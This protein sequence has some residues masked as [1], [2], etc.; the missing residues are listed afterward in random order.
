MSY[1]LFVTG[2]SL[3][4]PRLH[5]EHST[6]T[7]KLS[8]LAENLAFQSLHIQLAI[9]EL[10]GVG[11]LRLISQYWNS[12][13]STKSRAIDSEQPQAYLL[14]Q[15]QL[16]PQPQPQHNCQRMFYAQHGLYCDQPRTQNH[17]QFLLDQ[18]PK[19]HYLNYISIEVPFTLNSTIDYTVRTRNLGYGS[20]RGNPTSNLARVIV[21]LTSI[22]I[23]NTPIT[24]NTLLEPSCETIVL[25]FPSHRSLHPRQL[26]VTL[27][28]RL[29]FNT[30]RYYSGPSHSGV[31]TAPKAI[32]KLAVC[33]PTLWGLCPPATEQL[34]N[35]Q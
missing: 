11:H 26:S 5:T 19:F 20:S 4:V 31:L 15:S 14:Q 24:I 10:Q 29:Y 28:L 33:P 18:Y 12:L 7:S 3:K 13:R 23:Q 22:Q 34:N 17:L 16:Q 21:P 2:G 27:E 9:G 32:S 35:S 6:T 25:L 30:S 8:S 1:Q